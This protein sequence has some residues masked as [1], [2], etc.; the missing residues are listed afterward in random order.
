MRNR[1]RGCAP[2]PGPNFADDENARFYTKG[3][4][5]LCSCAII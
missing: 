4:D 3:L 1:G 5:K 2:P